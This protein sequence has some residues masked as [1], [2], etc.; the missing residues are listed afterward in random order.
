MLKTIIP[1][2]CSLLLLIAITMFARPAEQTW[3]G[4][5]SDSHCRMEHEP[6]SEG[7]PVLPAP[8]CVKLCLKSGYKYVFVADE[9]VFTI[10]NQDISDLAKFAGEV[11]KLTGDLKGDVITVSK[12]ERAGN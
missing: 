3:T 10:A 1:L 12:I 11:V 7:D 4:E 9:K 2:T 5:I 8:D 6:I